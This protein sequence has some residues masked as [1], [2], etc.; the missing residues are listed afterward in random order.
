MKIR[1]EWAN[2]WLGCSNRLF[3]A[4]FQSLFGAFFR[5]WRQDPRGK[6][7][8]QAGSEKFIEIFFFSA[9]ND[10]G[11]ESVRCSYVL[12]RA[13]SWTSRSIADAECWY[14]L[15]CAVF[16]IVRRT[17][18]LRESGHRWAPASSWLRCW[19]Y[20]VFFLF[21]F[22]YRWFQFH[23]HSLWS[24][25]CLFINFSLIGCC[26]INVT[27]L[28]TGTDVS[29]KCRKIQGFIVVA[30]VLCLLNSIY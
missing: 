13:N 16:V 27:P 22:I 20:L 1:V 10:S 7:F 6:F 21:S 24:I 29:L 3:L 19:I 2:L 11:L 12:K 8:F 25:E 18:P 26:F 28:T 15:A 9:S 5:V 14:T 17:C 4:I 23:V 30:N